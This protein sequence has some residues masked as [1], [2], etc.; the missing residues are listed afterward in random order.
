MIRGVLGGS[1]DP[2]HNGHVAM[3]R[4][5]L[6]RDLARIVHVIPARLSPHK[7]DDVADPRHR[8]AMAR[9]A[10]ADLPGVVVDE[11]EIKRPG[12][13]F[14]VDTL[15]DLAREFPGDE[16]LLIVG[17]DNAAGLAAWKDP[18][19]IGALATVA[20]LARTGAE[21]DGAPDKVPVPAGMRVRFF[22]DFHQPVS[23]TR[24]R[25]ILARTSGEGEDP[26]DFLP[27]GVA[28]YIEWHK[29]YR[30]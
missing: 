12:P 18:Q 1:F 10:F 25:A 17:E 8:L 23:S 9:L 11:R 19:R 22:P 21:G 6:E 4:F 30:D 7:K 15:T 28:S 20:V 2:V 3:A 5:V 27:P 13:S 16:L 24:I 26:A 14:T 29:L